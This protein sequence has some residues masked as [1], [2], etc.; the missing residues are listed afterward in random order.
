MNGGQNKNSISFILKSIE[1]NFFVVIPGI[2][3]VNFVS[4]IDIEIR[5]FFLVI[6][7]KKRFFDA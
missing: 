7:S 6:F 3:W 4:M 1:L 5:K 2:K